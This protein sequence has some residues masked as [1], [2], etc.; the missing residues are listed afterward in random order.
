VHE[1]SV[2]ERMVNIALAV[3]KEHGGG[4]IAGMRLLI[5]ALTC[6]D[7]ETLEFAFDVVTR[8]TA[9]EGFRL[10]V[11]AVRTRA[12][13]LSCGLEA[14]RDL[15]EPCQACAT[16]GGDVLAGR[17]LRVDTI[18]LDDESPGAPNGPSTEAWSRG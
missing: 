14:E 4:R 11:V 8:G 15:L 9:A 18:D 1:I 13:C 3:A 17:E 6:V 16:V 10:E 5:G 12:R 2:A 7:R